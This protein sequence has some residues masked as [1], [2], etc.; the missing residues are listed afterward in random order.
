MD[1]FAKGQQQVVSCV[2]V[3][4]TEEATGDREGREV[5]EDGEEVG[6]IQEH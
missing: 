2:F 3:S 1:C 6:Q 5:A 4:P